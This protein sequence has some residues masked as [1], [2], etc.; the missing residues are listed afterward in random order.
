M[1][2]TCGAE[3]DYRD[4]FCSKCGRLTQ[5][6]MPLGRKVEKLARSAFAF[7]SANVNRRQMI[8]GGVALAVVLI[9]LTDNPISAAIGRPFS[10]PRDV[11]G[12]IAWDRPQSFANYEDRFLSE[13]VEGR[14]TGSANVRDYPTTENTIAV[15]TLEAGTPVSGRWVQG[16][17]PG[18]R[19]LKLDMADGYMWEGNFGPTGVG[20]NVAALLFPGWAQGQ[21]SNKDF[22]PDYSD[23]SL[24]VVIQGERLYINGES[25]RLIAA[26]EVGG[27]TWFTLRS[28]K[29]EENMVETSIAIQ[30]SADGS[31]IVLDHIQPHD[32]GTWYLF[33]NSLQCA[34]LG[35]N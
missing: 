14:T 22:C 19:W 13:R 25:S 23:G 5:A 28:E 20:R 1:E 4:T 32:I 7:V 35:R 30:P 6:G 24:Y 8:G 17:D 34:Q 15:R 2:C 29:D 21:W 11:E 3:L 18:T 10:S 31:H 33:D 12:G 16:F 9:A 27:E 26:D